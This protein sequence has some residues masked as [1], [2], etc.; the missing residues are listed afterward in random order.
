[1]PMKVS[2]SAGIQQLQYAVSL[3]HR[4]VDLILESGIEFLQLMEIWQARY[5]MIHGTHT[6]CENIL[7]QIGCFRYHESK[8]R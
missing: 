2:S 8:D 5:A 7:G 3:R 6:E 4:K 1:M